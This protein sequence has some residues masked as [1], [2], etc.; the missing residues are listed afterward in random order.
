MAFWRPLRRGLYTLTHR[1][2]TDRQV[3]DE[4]AHYLDEAT[5][6]YVASGLTRDQARRAARLELGN[7]AVVREDVRSYGWE[8]VVETAF[9]DLRYGA[10]R[11]RS[12]PGFAA[13]AVLTLALGIGA[14]TAVFSAAKPI[15]F[16][17]LPYPEARRI[18]TI[19]G[20]RDGRLACAGDFWQ[21]SRDQRTISCL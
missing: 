10:R 4:V 21:L 16:D 12:S 19:W 13:I 15:L 3:A 8:N 17:S 1:D 18:M 6:A 7:P 5:D 2:S 14:S 11:L 9:A 20:P